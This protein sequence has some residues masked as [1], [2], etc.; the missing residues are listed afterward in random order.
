MVLLNLMET[1]LDNNMDDIDTLTA[2]L[3]ENVV[4]PKA[5]E[6]HTN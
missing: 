3:G 1:P 2:E 5:T 4:D 6:L